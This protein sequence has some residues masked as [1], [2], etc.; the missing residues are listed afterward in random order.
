MLQRRIRQIAVAAGL[1]TALIAGCGGN[2]D[3]DYSAT[4]FSEC[5][6]GRDL[7]P[8]KMDTSPSSERYV[9]ALARIGAEAARQNGALEAFAND[10]MPG[11][12]TLY[13]L[14]FEDADTARDGQRRL[15]RVAR[16][17]KA[18]D[19]LVV[20]GNLLTVG[21]EQTEAQSRV[22]DECLNQSES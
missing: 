14:F 6:S 21:P 1:L 3:V 2:S 4:R 5:L 7:A 17:E 10:A 22:V 8:E 18:N 16:E 9:D 13:F 12:S 15:E 20:R 11:A 19:Q